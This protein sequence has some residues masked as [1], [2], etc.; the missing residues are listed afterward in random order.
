MV[1]GAATAPHANF[2]PTAA[3]QIEAGLAGSPVTQKRVQAVVDRV[4]SRFPVTDFGIGR[5][6]SD[7]VVHPKGWPADTV[8]TVD[9]SDIT[10]L[11]EAGRAGAR[12]HVLRDKEDSFPTFRATDAARAGKYLLV[13]GRIAGA[14][15]AAPSARVYRLSHGRWQET[16]VRDALPEEAWQGHG[17]VKRPEFQPDPAHPGMVRFVLELRDSPHHFWQCH[18]C[19]W[20]RYEERWLFADGRLRRTRRRRVNTPLAELDDLADL[21]NRGDCAAFDARVPKRLRRLV[22]GRLGAAIDDD[23]GLDPV[24]NCP[25]SDELSDLCPKFKGQGWTVRLAKHGSGWRVANAVR[26]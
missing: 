13:F 23:I 22:W 2:A 14:D 20:L 19:P 21:V 15:F 7:A 4:L 24:G 11:V 6:T 1:L 26:S 5:G 18:M 16:Q 10:F 17:E 8:V 25:D 3:R 12:V 9:A